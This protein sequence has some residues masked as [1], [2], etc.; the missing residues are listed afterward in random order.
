LGLG[1]GWA[2]DGRQCL[3]RILRGRRDQVERRVNRHRSR[4]RSGLRGGQ[5][6]QHI[7]RPGCVLLRSRGELLPQ[8]FKQS[9]ID[10]FARHYSIGDVE[11]PK[12]FVREIHCSGI[13]GCRRNKSVRVYCALET[14]LVR[15]AKL[16]VV[17]SHP[18]CGNSSCPGSTIGNT[19]RSPQ[20][21]SCTRSRG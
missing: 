1:L 5:G 6:I 9:T 4:L 12:L 16:I 15:Q 3:Q 8:S 13:F 21:S 2:F 18:G 17:L 20:T 11:L 7:L 10:R 19:N 14:T